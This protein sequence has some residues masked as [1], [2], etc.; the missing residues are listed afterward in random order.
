MLVDA[1]SKEIAE[2]KAG[3]YVFWH[4][5]QW[6]WDFVADMYKHVHNLMV[7]ENQRMPE[8][9]IPLRFG[10]G[11]WDG[12]C[13][14]Y[15]LFGNSK[16]EPSSSLSYVLR[17]HD[18]SY[19]AINKYSV[20]A[21][22]KQFGLEP[23]FDIYKKDFSELQKLHKKA[24]KRGYGSLLMISVRP[25][26]MRYVFRAQEGS[27]GKRWQ[28]IFCDGALTHNAKK[29]ID[30]LRTNPVAVQGG[31]TDYIEFAMF[32]TKEYALDPRKGLRIF[33]FGATDAGKMADYTNKRDALFARIAAD[34]K[35]A[36]VI[37]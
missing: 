23:F 35:A 7:P 14:N 15:A 6:E 31:E 1:F 12:F 33:A 26:D 34:L 3:N 36:G 11:E 29:I 4:G 22:F 21:F 27:M 18:Y 8:T 28:D 20:Q 25:D 30:T 2:S 5:R 24:N 10:D 19:G 13:M 32:L 37:Q 16:R 17:N 9:Y